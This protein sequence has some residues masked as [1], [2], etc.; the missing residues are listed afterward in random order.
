MRRAYIKDILRTI[1]KNAKRF[2]A[3]LS[4]AAL[5]LTAFLGINA[6]CRD[7]YIAA[8]RLYDQQRLFDI[9]V[10][11]TLGLTGEDVE[12]LQNISGVEI[13]DGTYSETV[14]TTLKNT[15][16]RSIEIVTIS[17]K[18]INM[19]YLVQG[20]L[21]QKA[22]EIAVT[23]KYLD[24]SGKTIGD[25]LII[26]EDTED[27]EDA[28]S[29]ENKA[30]AEKAGSVENKAV[31]EEAGSTE[32]KA[33][34]K[35]A[36]STENAPMAKDKGMSSEQAALTKQEA[37][38][39]ADEDE[40]GLSE[41][42]AGLDTDVDWDTEI[43]IEEEEEKPTFL[44]TQYIITGIVV[45]P[46]DIANNKGSVAF[47]SAA[48]TD[49]TFYVTPA[50]V[51]SDV[52]TAVYL[53]LRGLAE[54]DCYSEEY[55]NAIQSVIQVIESQIM[56]QREQIRYDTI[57]GKALEKITDA[58]TIMNDNF[59]EAD[60]KFA[61]AWKEIEDAKQELLDGEAELTGE[62]KDALKKLAAARTKLEDGKE[63]LRNA[64]AEA[65]EGKAKLKDN[66]QKLKEGRAQLVRERREAEDGFAKAEQQ[67]KEKLTELEASR[68][69]L[70]PTIEQLQ[71]PF[72]DQWPEAQWSALI[73]A[74]A[75]KTAEFVAANPE[76]DP[77][78]A[79]VAA[80]TKEEQNALAATL[81]A[82]I[83][84]LEHFP[85]DINTSEYIGNCVQSGLGL[86]VIEGGNQVLDAQKT[87]YEKQKSEG[88]QQIADAEAK[89]DRNE[90]KLEAARQQL[91]DGQD[92]ITAGWAEITKN[93][94]KLNTEEA[95]ALK[96]LKDA[97]KELDDGKQELT[98]G[99]TKL[100]KNEEKYKDK[101]A[102][103][104]GKLSDAYAELE[105]IDMAQWYVQDRT[106]VDSYSSLDS[107]LSSVGAIGRVFPI[108][109]LVVAVLICLTTM[110]RMVEEERSLIGTY[111]ALGFGNAA[112]GRKYILYSLLAS[113]A[114]SMFG[115]LLGFLVL[116]KLLIDILRSIYII[117][118]TILHFDA[119]YSMAGTL[120]FM[121][122]IIL[123]T[124][125]ACHNELRQMPAALMRPKAPSVGSRI[126]LERIPKVWNHLKFLNKVTA[127]NL[128]RY[129]KRLFM[130]VVGIA[131]CTALVLT[132]FAIR[133]S[134][135]DMMPKQYEDIYRYDLMVVSDAE[136]NDK[137][138]QQLDGDEAIADFLSVQLGSVKVFNG[139]GDSESMQMVVVPTGASLEPY[140]H[141]PDREGAEVQLDSKGIFITSNAAGQ[142]D[143]KPGDTVALQNL[144]LDRRNT[145]ISNVVD[146]YLG[147]SVFISQT[148]YE[149][150]FGKYEPNAA[151]AHFTE[152]VTDQAAYA[153]DLLEKEYVMSS[154]STL[155][156]KE[157]FSSNFVI[158][159]SVIFILIVLAAGLAFVV[160]FTLSNTNISERVRELA[161]IKVLGFFD[162]EVHA[163]VNKET[164]ILTLI[165][166]LAGL[167]LGHV[168]SGLLLAALKMPSFQFELVIQPESYIIAGVISLSFTFL[169]NI[170]TNRILD[171]INMV[172]ALK[173]IE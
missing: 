84:K 144:Q 68:S 168:L 166:I 152:L 26:E 59:T 66:E 167:P 3:I 131:G 96:E 169:V 153:D 6:A 81:G 158:L 148:L 53:T 151:Y 8:D 7:M 5:G 13:A 60:Q 48:A 39:A 1:R 161:T 93:E 74:S 61:D 113:A 77:D 50:N 155:K 79:Q 46:M 154:I 86:G 133:D 2:L 99:E 42:N 49:Y 150:L 126:L 17:P 65:A 165:G 128:F 102:E 14:Y 85:P 101:K 157:E 116:P 111:K 120:L 129:K 91:K 139:A 64:E 162:G 67:F 35:G 103:A 75:S 11:S 135:T 71:A 33:V 4:I 9:R 114:G 43:D 72:G 88:L 31:T 45:G 25:T 109:F 160:L 147:N 115:N 98:D 125:L 92:E 173:S 146:N 171:K 141:T 15:M 110:T 70:L 142:L 143:L 124:A 164:L 51:D 52:Y 90:A 122:S 55:V 130:T 82:V 95:K 132:G 163:Y 19:P 172:E 138:I 127:R 87:A 21:P 89:L 16:R 119:L 106:S 47:R 123:A 145:V 117:P 37:P 27:Q 170:I 156:L 44:N 32:K 38:K 40:S 30:V 104:E 12:V 80:A 159:N 137:L 57:M 83:P 94:K 121:G 24:E 112:I 69:K 108:L 136:D 62:E 58:E 36:G 63:Q 54:L 29:A 78:P 73:S 41:D 149:A 100:I 56:E 134:V 105:E 107:D 76:S 18:G 34:T 28:N 22:G 118:N 97:W 23:Q 10:L 20:T 140:I